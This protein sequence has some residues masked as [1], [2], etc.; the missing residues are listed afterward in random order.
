MYK[1]TYWLVRLV[2]AAVA[3]IA[4]S[5]PAFALPSPN[6]G[7]SQGNEQSASSV[8]E[9][10]SV[11]ANVD[12]ATNLKQA[13]NYYNQ[14]VSLQQQGKLEEAIAQYHEAIRLNPDLAVAHLNL[15]AALAATG[16]REE[17]IIAY[18][19]AIALEPT[20]PE[21]YYN[22][23]NALAQQ[24]SLEEAIAQYHQ[25]I[26]INPQYAK[27]YYNLGNVFAQQGMRDA[28]IT[29]WREA[30]RIQPEFAEAYANLGLILSRS[31]QRREAVEAFKKA[32]DLFKAQGK[33]QQAEQ[34]DR[35]LQ[36]IGTPPTAIT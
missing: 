32:R 16:K 1:K 24:G 20:L 2:A 13:E 34:V 31:G 7:N 23:A 12:S 33:I 19:Q 9:N 8:P 3:S 30:V 10:P 35:L 36:R 5:S 28:A 26:R 14:G 25:A 21:A 27:A 22:L 29:Q 15:G 6:L 18:K 11:G 17:A 4:L